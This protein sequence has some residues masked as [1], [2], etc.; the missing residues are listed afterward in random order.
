[1]RFL[2]GYDTMKRLSIGSRIKWMKICALIW[3]IKDREINDFQFEVDNRGAGIAL[4]RCLQ[5]VDEM[6]LNRYLARVDA[7]T[8]L[9]STPDFNFSGGQVSAFGSAFF[10]TN[11]KILAISP[12]EKL[13]G[14]TNN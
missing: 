4:D 13:A 10:K 12:A 3:H 1:V 9:N 14:R 2:N 8:S 6:L 7:G 11:N 5:T